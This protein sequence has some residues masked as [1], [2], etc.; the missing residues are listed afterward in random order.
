MSFILNQIKYTMQT[1]QHEPT[2]ASWSSGRTDT[3]L[4]PEIL[5]KAMCG[6]MGFSQE[7]E[8]DKKQGETR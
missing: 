8:A 3:S 2:S 1:G 5:L 4:C 7:Q 6:Q